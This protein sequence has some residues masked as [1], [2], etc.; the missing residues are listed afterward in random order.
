LIGLSKVAIRGDDCRKQFSVDRN[1]IGTK[2][3][4]LTD[5]QGMHVSVIISLSSSSVTTYDINW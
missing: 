2:R 5:K 4:I 3:H 1:E